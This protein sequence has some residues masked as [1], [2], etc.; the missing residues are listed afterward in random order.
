MPLMTLT[1]FA[2]AAL[3]AA[4]LV[5]GQTGASRA[6]DIVATEQIAGNRLSF[7]LKPTF[8][9]ATLSVAGPN[10]FHA[11]MFTKSGELALNL[12]ASG[13]LNDGTYMFQIT[14][15]GGDKVAVRTPLDNGRDKLVTERPVIVST[16]G[17]F[18][19]RNGEIVK[20]DP[21]KTERKDR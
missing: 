5:A 12:A 13:K 7:V 15:S 2:S 16:S 18:Q 8:T 14:A 1:P 20:P 10:D 11:S 21:T 6:D 19:V 3:L 4:A 17:S 9:N